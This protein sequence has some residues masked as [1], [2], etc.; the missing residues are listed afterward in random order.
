ME[1][2]SHLH[3]PTDS[4]PGI[5]ALGTHRIGHCV[6]ARAGLDIVEKR[7]SLAMPGIKIKNLG[8]PTQ[9]LVSVPNEPS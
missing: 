8:H 4:S 1:V 3:S 7:H 5:R 6:G 9:S 2:R